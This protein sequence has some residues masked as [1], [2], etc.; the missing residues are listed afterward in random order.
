[1]GVFNALDID[2]S[3]T[4]DEIIAKIKDDGETTS[5]NS[6]SRVRR[7][8]LFRCLRLVCTTGVLKETISIDKESTFSLTE[9]G[10]LLQSKHDAPSS[11]SPFF[12]HWAEEPI[13]N[14]WS[15]LP[16]FVVGKDT[17][18]TE[19]EVNT[20]FQVRPLF[21][22]A[23]GMC[24]SEYYKNNAA[25]CAHRNAVARYASTRE[26]PAILNSMKHSAVLNESILKGSTIVDI[27]GGY[28][29]LMY[30]LKTS[31]P[32]IGKCYCMDLPD[33][34]SDASTSDT[35]MNN[36]NPTKIELIPGNMFDSS[37]IPKCDI[38][39]AKHVL[40]DF[41]DEDVILALQSFRKKL[42]NKKGKVIIMDAVLPNED[43]LNGIW[44][45]AVSFDVLLMLSGRRGER[46]R[47]EWS[48]LA[49][50]AGFILDDV[51]S[52]SSVTVDLAIL[53]P[54]SI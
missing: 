49:E 54:V 3:L 38:I 20:S 11:M 26:I 40:C 12:L 33:V 31:M 23:N 7:D 52:T 37:T 2:A 28:G 16:E 51:L 44:N 4:V 25:S 10:Q 34:I 46:S 30:A 24:A 45:P 19:E 47:L 1:M 6:S 9:M 21:D 27:G 29:D 36:E 48:N 39:M 43:D 42:S 13:W 35:I 15:K 50:E 32:S 8:A 18:D 53:S 5:D 22:R 14:A 17:A 41:D